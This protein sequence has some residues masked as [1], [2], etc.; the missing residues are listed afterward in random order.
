MAMPLGEV[1][2]LVIRL[3]IAGSS[4]VPCR[5]FTNLQQ[6]LLPPQPSRPCSTLPSVIEGV[7]LLGP[8][9]KMPA[10]AAK[11]LIHSFHEPLT[12]DDINIIAKMTTLSRDA[13][14]V[15][16]G[17]VGPDYVAEEAGV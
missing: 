12:D 3:E 13:L 15:V 14:W 17:L 9:E 5:L 4:A 16:A 8:N 1:I 2:V 10:K 11:A 7:G 6:T